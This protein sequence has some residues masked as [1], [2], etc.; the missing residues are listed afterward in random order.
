M[1]EI[2]KR[3][4]NDWGDA[5]KK[6]YKWIYNKLKS[7]MPNFNYEEDDY[8]LKMSKPKLLTFIKKLDLG[9]SSREA[10]FFTISKYL[11]LF[12][13]KDN[14]AYQNFQREGHKLLDA[15]KKKEGENLVDDKHIE[16][17]QNFEYF[18]KILK[19]K[20]YKTI[21]NLKEHNEYLLLSLLI[22]QPPLRTSFYSTAILTTTNKTKTDDKNNYLLLKTVM[23]KNRGF[24]IVNNDKVSN[25]KQFKMDISKNIIEIDNAALIELLNYSIQKF[26]RKYLFENDKG[27]KISEDTLR[28]YLRKI[29]KLPNINF[30][31]MRSI[32]ISEAYRTTAKTVNQREKLSI[33]MRH[34]PQIAAA[35]YFKIKPDDET[36]NK[37]NNEVINELKNKNNELTIE[38]NELK[39]KLSE[40]TP[41]EN[42]KIFLKRKAD[43]V[44]RLKA[45]KN[46]KSD[47]I[48]KYNIKV[49][50]LKK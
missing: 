39:S 24:Y 14:K 3:I 18:L 15:S 6:K 44:A 34:S 26:P 31:I 41:T 11:Q 13:E 49:D 50:S 42:D 10:M 32:F 27:G 8:I 43:I 20:E 28:T 45:G 35:S 21:T 29:T 38:N 1:S 30:D 25:S 12:G 36:N 5:D 23:G 37:N 48:Q 9:T 33:M 40:V 7:G 22:L 4:K 17:Y 2:R 16:S 46:V 19:D 47:T